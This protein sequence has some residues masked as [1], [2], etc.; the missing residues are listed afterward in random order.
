M[1]RGQ[2]GS[3]TRITGEILP[4]PRNRKEEEFGERRMEKKQKWGIQINHLKQQSHYTGNSTC[5]NRGEKH[6]NESNHNT[7]P[8]GTDEVCI[9]ILHCG[10]LV[11]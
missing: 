10:R 6:R 7:N 4:L 3:H 9:V 2:S 11:R 1:P 8:C 5:E